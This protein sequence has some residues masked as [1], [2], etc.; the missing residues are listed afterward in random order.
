MVSAHVVFIGA[1]LPLFPFHRDH[2]R[3]GKHT[4]RAPSGN[5]INVLMTPRMEVGG[6]GGGS[7]NL[8]GTIMILSCFSAWSYIFLSKSHC[9]SNLVTWIRHYR[10]EAIDS[11]CAQRVPGVAS[12]TLFER[13][14]HLWQVALVPQLMYG[15]TLV[16]RLRSGRSCPQTCRPFLTTLKWY[17][18]ETN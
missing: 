1:P 2:T 4:W 6:K 18:N 13:S 10:T 11:A 5:T 17:G 7:H 15:W 16:A 3:L 14:V 8:M 12:C 9:H